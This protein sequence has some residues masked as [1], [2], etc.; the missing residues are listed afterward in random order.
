[1]TSTSNSTGSI[2]AL[3]GNHTGPGMSQFN[4][5][6]STIYNSPQSSPIQSSFNDE[7]EDSKPLDFSSKSSPKTAY[8]MIT[9]ESVDL[10]KML[11]K[12]HPKFFAK[13]KQSQVDHCFTTPSPSPPEHH[14]SST[15]QIYSKNSFES[16]K[17]VAAL[18]NQQQKPM[19]LLEK[20]FREINQLPTNDNR[21]RNINDTLLQI[22]KMNY[23]ASNGDLGLLD[24]QRQNPQLAQLLLQLDPNIEILI[25]S[26]QKQQQ[27]QKH[28]EKQSSISPPISPTV[29]SGRSQS[30]PK[31]ISPVSY[32]H[33]LS[34]RHLHSPSQSNQL[35]NEEGLLNTNTF[36]KSQSVGERSVIDSLINLSRKQSH[37]DPTQSS[38]NSSKITEPL[39]IHNSTKELPSQSSPTHLLRSTSTSVQLDP[40][41][42]QSLLGSDQAYQMFRS[43]ILEAK[44]QTN[45]RSNRRSSR[46]SN[47]QHSDDNSSNSSF[48]GNSS[49]DQSI[50]IENGQNL[51]IKEDLITSNGLQLVSA[52][53][54]PI[55]DV[56][57]FINSSSKISAANN[58]SV[59]KRGRPLP[60]D[61]KDEAYWERRR[62]NNEAAKR[63]RDLRR[64]KED[65]IAIRACFLEQENRQLKCELLQMKM[66]L[67]KLRTLLTQLNHPV[68]FL[69]NGTI[70]AST[71]ANTASVK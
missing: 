4:Q 33:K 5:S 27:E 54:N 36:P 1:M 43:Q 71:A 18:P 21:T 8:S 15:G 39:K 64:A 65:E 55:T 37:P 70:L 31:N 23:E 46:S 51:A 35:L 13:Q 58:S 52:L 57:Q 63:S 7:I 16:N 32:P 20:F 24:H 11:K 6:K 14:I 29:S 67:D 41:A 40:S 19:I 53:Q 17:D 68:G 28:Q 26:F 42:A 60:E 10:P 69:T 62:K 50:Q 47:S 34:N 38:R 25:N 12:M 44:R 9:P 30:S 61:Q 49:I 45:P 2:I 56:N 66:E 3:F 59:R 48:N 22:M